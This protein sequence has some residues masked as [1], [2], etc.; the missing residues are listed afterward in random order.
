MTRVNITDVKVYPFDTRETGGGTLA[1]AEI[2]IE[3]SLLIK[4]LH[5][6]QSRGGGLFVSF[7]AVKGRD[8]KWR[9]I[10]VPLD[11]ETKDLIRDQVLE[12]Y[13]DLEE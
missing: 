4:G 13:R 11:S 7:P 10:V 6:I 1:I 12:A 5:V 8:G 9:D 3:G 2:T